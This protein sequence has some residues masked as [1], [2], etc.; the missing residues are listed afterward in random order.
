M[1]GTPFRVGVIE[2]QGLA[3][4]QIKISDYSVRCVKA[5]VENRGIVHLK[6][7]QVNK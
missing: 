5:N 6:V 3:V 2:V 1:G 4:K 7:S